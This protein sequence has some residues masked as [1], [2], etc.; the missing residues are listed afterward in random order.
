M[1]L[2]NF[3]HPFSSQQ[4]SQLETLVGQAVERVVELPMQLDPALPFAPQ[5]EEFFRLVPLD[6]RAF[7]SADIVVALPSLNFA[8]ALV[9]AELHSRMG[10]FPAVV[11][12]RTSSGLLPR[13]EVAEVL[14]LQAIRAQSRKAR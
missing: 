3:S 9:L 4:I 11:R 7:Q 5:V 12:L 14:D 13:Y 1:I 10:H 6:G 2:L 8:A